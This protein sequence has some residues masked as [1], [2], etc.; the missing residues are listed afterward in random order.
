MTC[1]LQYQGARDGAV[2]RAF[3]SVAQNQIPA[4]TPYVS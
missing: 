4:L 3:V 1:I 2:M